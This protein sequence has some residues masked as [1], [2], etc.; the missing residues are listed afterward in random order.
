[1][2]NQTNPSDAEWFSGPTPA[3]TRDISSAFSEIKF[4]HNEW[5]ELIAGGRYDLYSLQGSGNFINAC[6]PFATRMQAA[7]LG[8]QLRKDVSPLHSLSR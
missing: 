5:L 3:G 6:G 4:K 1:M 8:R 7:I 2:T